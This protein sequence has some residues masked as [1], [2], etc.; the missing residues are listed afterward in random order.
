MAKRSD[1]TTLR[2]IAKLVGLSVATVSSVINESGRVSPATRQRVLQAAK[3]LDYMPNLA[4]R[5]LHR[6]RTGVIGVLIGHLSHAS[7]EIVF[8]IDAEGRNQGRQLLIVT[9]EVTPDD[10][11]RRIR[12]LASGLSDAI[13]LI[14]PVSPPEQ[15][16][17]LAALDVPVVLA[18]YRRPGAGLPLVYG[19]NLRISREVTEHLI[20]LGHRKIAF[21]TG[22][23]GSGQSDERER[24]YHIALGSAGLPYDE[25]LVFEGDFSQ[26]SGLRAAE[27]ILAL[28]AGG[29]TAVFAANDEMALGVIEGFTRAGAIVPLDYSVVGFNAAPTLRSRTELTTVQHRFREVGVEATRLIDRLTSATPEQRA[30]LQLT[31][32]EVPSTLEL[33]ESTAQPRE[34]RS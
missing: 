10:E 28:R 12:D 4:A 18:N 31:E 3:A 32:I 7:F 21:I 11:A 14:S 27:R 22:T 33:R 6:A 8:G 9:T 19:E 1:A 17:K 20:A 34:L 5:S 29:P 23:H 26:A 16:A 24:G 30:K 2:D 15:L 13:I 25:D